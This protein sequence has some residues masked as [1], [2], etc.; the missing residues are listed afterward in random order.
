MLHRHP[1]GPGLRL[2]AVAGLVAALAC[3]AAVVPRPGAAAPT[4][5][6][7]SEYVEGSGSNKALEIFNGTASSVTLTG[8]YDIQI[9]AN[10]S[11]TATATI[12]LNGSIPAGD[13]HVL[14]RSASDAALLAL[15]DE[16]TTNFLW[17]GNDAVALRHGGSVI[18]VIGQ[19]GFDP[20]VEWGTADT[21]TSDHTLRRRAS[22]QAGDADGAGVFDPATGWLGFSIDTFDGLGQHTIGGGD[23]GTNTPPLAV[24]D[25]A[26]ISEDQS[27]V[28]IPVLANDVDP[29]ADPLEVISTSDAANGEVAITAG[30]TGV[31][32]GP[33]VDF[34][35]SDTFSYTAADGRGGTTTASVTVTVAPVNDDPDVEDDAGTTAEDVPGTFDVVGNDQDVDGD[36]L[37]VTGVDGAEHGST[38]VSPDG[39]SVIYAPAPDFN[40]SDAVEVTV[41]DGHGGLDLSE[42]IVTVSAANDPPIAASDIASVIQGGSIVVDVLANDAAGPANETGQALSVSSVGAPAHGTTE[43]VVD[44]PDAGRVR[45]TPAAGFQGADS[46]TYVVSDGEATATGTVNVAVAEPVLVSLCA[47]LPTISGTLGADTIVGTPGDDVIRG[48]RGNDVIDGNGGNDVICGGAGGDRITT[49][50][51]RDA[52]AGGSGADTIES[53]DGDD[54]VRGGFGRDTLTTGAGSDRVT[55]GPGADTITAGDGDNRVAAGDGDDAITAG[56]GNDRIDGG[57]GTDTCDPGGGRNA[58]RNCE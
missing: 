40:G 53:G 52:I 19:I 55:A 36:A 29:D 3:L 5:L 16:T 34:S 46:F 48:R 37:V 13:T 32:Y 25:A 38:T 14:V 22:V 41:S 47:A 6:F 23:P 15:A 51:G 8:S 30:G 56:A 35:G 17:N 44:G 18:D 58:V 33:D 20:G 42:L 54:R 27:P 24:D 10:G 7:L 4:E 28:T 49:H 2:L 39:R 9:F 57:P 50:D 1:P 45:Y 31:S 26:S 21:T 12:P 43:L 11:P